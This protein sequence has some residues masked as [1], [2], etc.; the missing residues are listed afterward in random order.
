M[1]FLRS[2]IFNVFLYVFT[3]LSSIVAMLVAVLRPR[4][5]A[6]FARWWSRAWLKVYEI[7]CGVSYEVKGRENMPEGGC[8]IAMKHQST[9]D[10]FAM[11][12]I[13][14]E[15]V[16]VFKRE[17]ARIPFFGWT[18]LRM[19]CIP[20]Q[21]GTGKAAL[22]SMIQG[23]V[24]ACSRGKQVVIFPEGTRG[25]VGQ[26]AAYKTGVSHL[27]QATGG[28][29]VPVAL[30]SGLLWPRHKFLRPPGIITVEIL[31]PIPP[32]LPRKDMQ[33]R[34]VD[35]IEKASQRLSGR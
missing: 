32:G 15:P 17:L 20:V 22:D 7:V 6:A 12:A 28:S 35:D 5:S 2:L 25:V 1:L 33:L 13:F 10:T 18:L 9:W 4:Q 30:N 19:G 3:A 8:V 23:T 21:R 31:P 16:F 14:R 34:L 11:F 27:Y 29:F 24:T 26:A